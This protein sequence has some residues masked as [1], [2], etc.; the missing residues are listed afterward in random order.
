V[1]EIHVRQASA[2][3]GRTLLFDGAE[4]L[5]IESRIIQ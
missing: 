4:C 1:E 3:C 5:P 2:S